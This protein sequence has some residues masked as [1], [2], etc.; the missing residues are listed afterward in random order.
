M[1]HSL[2]KI[3]L[4]IL[5]I[6]GRHFQLGNPAGK[7]PCAVP[8]PDE[9]G[10]MKK[11]PEISENIFVWQ[12]PNAL[13]S[14]LYNGVV[15]NEHN[16]V[17]RR[18]TE[19]PWGR[20]IHPCLCSPYLGKS[21]G[22]L[23]KAIFLMTPE[24]KGN[25]YHWIA[26]LLPRILLVQK[27]GL[28][29]FHERRLVL[30]QPWRRY[31]KDTLELLGIR[32]DRIV[33]LRPFE[34]LKV[35]DLIVPDFLHSR[36][37]QSFP[38]WKK[39]LMDGFKQKVLHPEKSLTYKR[40]YLLRGKQH[41]RR[42]MN[43]EYLVAKLKELDFEIL[44]PQQMSLKEQMKALADAQVVVGVHGAALVNIIFCQEGTHVIELR[45][46]YKPPEHYS[47]IAK[48]YKL[49]FE[50]ITLAPEK[51]AEAKNLANK[52]NLLLTKK[53]LETLLAKVRRPVPA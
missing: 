29:D 44:D 52:Q 45:S 32:E 42:L 3:S 43:E 17:Y 39:Q 35:K 22:S 10:K 18:F 6:P 37:G 53:D 16:E 8:Q 40:I 9:G 50:S 23:E 14:G 49:R 20:E 26:D 38:V 4:K 21:V 7:V 47:E 36:D 30:H 2:F 13:C 1:K 19:F 41:T 24:A 15:I 51:L 33:R 12:L 27:C 46:I 11:F 28:S 5:R 48:T 25:Y 31:E 34:T